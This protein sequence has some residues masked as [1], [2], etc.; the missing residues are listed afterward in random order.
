MT[1]TPLAAI[2]LPAASS[3]V[4]LPSRNRSTFSLW[5]SF[6]APAIA[7]AGSLFVSWT[8]IV[9][10][11]PLS[12]PVS[13]TH[14]PHALTTSTEYLTDG[15]PVPVASVSRPILTGAFVAAGA[16]LPPADGCDAEPL[17]DE[18]LLDDPPHALASATTATAAASSRAPLGLFSIRNPLVSPTAARAAQPR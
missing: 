9:T 1:G 16:L 6:C 12:P 15:P 5:S 3:A 17:L 8:L 13:L 7:A 10:G 11:W 2:C 14:L 4:G 18:L